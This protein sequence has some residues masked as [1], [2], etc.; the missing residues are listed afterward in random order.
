MG[1][2]GAQT[3]V[4]PATGL[5][6]QGAL[7]TSAGASERTTAVAALTSSPPSKKGEDSY[8]AWFGFNQ[9]TFGG[10]LFHRSPYCAASLKASHRACPAL[11]L[12]TKERYTK[13]CALYPRS[14]E[15]SLTAHLV[16]V[17]LPTVLNDWGEQS[18]LTSHGSAHP[19]MRFIP[20]S[21][22]N[23]FQQGPRD[24]M[25]ALLHDELHRRA[26]GRAAASCPDPQC[27]RPGGCQRVGTYRHGGCSLSGH[28]GR[29][30]TGARIGRQPSNA[31]TH[32]SVEAVD[33]RHGHRVGSVVASR[34]RS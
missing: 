31:E 5:V 21:D 13:I 9:S 18:S 15:R 12:A 25:K 17:A 24:S 16:C 10:F 4:A 8:E 32:R 11:G 7:R 22:A 28:R 2:P 23:K 1:R 20:P 29:V 3:E 26:M 6:Q 30:E 34:D 33:R 27:E 14:Q 19:A